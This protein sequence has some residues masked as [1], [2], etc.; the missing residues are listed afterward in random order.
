M[1]FRTNL[2][3]SILSE[4]L[5]L[6]VTKALKFFFIFIFFIFIEVKIILVAFLRLQTIQNL[7]FSS[8]FIEVDEGILHWNFN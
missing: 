4:Y 7:L 5:Y 1:F 2:K 8:L 3:C 6:V